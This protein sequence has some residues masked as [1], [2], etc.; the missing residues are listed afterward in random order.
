MGRPSFDEAVDIAKQYRD[1]LE[2]AGSTPVE[3]NAKFY[4][5]HP[6]TLI[7]L[8]ERSRTDWDALKLIVERLRTRG[9]PLSPDLTDWAVDAF[10]GKRPRPTARGKDPYAYRVRDWLI[11]KAIAELR[12]AG[13]YPTRGREKGAVGGK[14]CAKGG[15]ACDAV[16][17]AF[18]LGYD[19][20]SKK[21]WE[22]FR[23]LERARE[24]LSN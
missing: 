21:I 15:S 23:G 19:V 1:A 8:S 5:S 18:S 17:M 16:G 11:Y 22:S 20:V 4:R 9:E 12:T 14:A 10:V 7:N 6:E 13:F 2:A 24:R 3:Q